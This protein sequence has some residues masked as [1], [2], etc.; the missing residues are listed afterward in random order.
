MNIQAQSKPF[1]WSFSKLKNYETCP[2]RYYEIDH[3]KSVE[4]P[5]TQ[6]LDRGDRLHASM[7]DRVVGSTPLPPEFIYMEKWAEKLSRV[8]EPCQ[9]IQGELKLATDRQW[10]PTGYFAKATWV[11]TKI[12][13]LRQMR[14]D[15]GYDIGHVVDY[16]TGK[17]PRVWDGTQLIINAHMIFTHFKH[18]Q[19]IRVDYLWT[20]WDD[21]THETYSRSDV[22]QQIPAIEA[23]VTQLEL[24]HKA[25]NF[26]PKP[27]GLCEEYCDVTSCEH[28]GKPYRRR[29]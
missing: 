7:Y 4:Q 5:R 19:R 23:R 6:E 15:N 20:E 25:D 12:D 18:I 22:A 29:A 10:Q 14:N 17:P 3:K 9:I 11:R 27:N 2:R 13:Y 26:P 16:K 24:A 28:W 1:T 21:T 8:L